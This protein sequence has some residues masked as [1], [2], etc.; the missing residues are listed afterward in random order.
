MLSLLLTIEY[1]NNIVF[2]SEQYNSE[3]YYFFRIM[4]WKYHLFAGIGMIIF[5]FLIN[6]Y[7]DNKKVHY[8]LGLCMTI[9]GI[10]SFINT[11]YLIDYIHIAFSLIMIISF[12]SLFTVSNNQNKSVSYE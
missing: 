5:Y 6:A 12:I 10:L 11:N 9:T 8:F 2:N 3:L 7:T 1:Y 4:L